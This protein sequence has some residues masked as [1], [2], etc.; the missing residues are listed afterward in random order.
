ME[1]PHQQVLPIN[2]VPFDRTVTRRTRAL[3]TL[4]WS[5]G[6]FAALRSDDSSSIPNSSIDRP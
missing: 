1:S 5:G 3:Y 2:Q 4:R 6:K